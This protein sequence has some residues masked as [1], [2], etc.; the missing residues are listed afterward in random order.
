[1]ERTDQSMV[2]TWDTA[3]RPIIYVVG[4]PE[5]EEREKQYPKT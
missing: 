4:V 1:M 5:E 3:E 2:G